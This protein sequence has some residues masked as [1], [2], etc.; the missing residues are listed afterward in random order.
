MLSF[1]TCLITTTKLSNDL[2]YSI[3]KS[4][5]TNKEALALAYEGSKTFDPK[6]LPRFLCPCTRA[7]RSTTGRPVSSNKARI[8]PLYLVYRKEAQG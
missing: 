4:I 5:C 8:D 7:L 3:T 1:A 2:A 6:G